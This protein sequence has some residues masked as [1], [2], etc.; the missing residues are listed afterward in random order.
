MPPHTETADCNCAEPERDAFLSWVGRLVHDHR[1]HLLQTRRLRHPS[2]LRNRE[3]PAQ[4]GESDGS[5]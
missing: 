3:R 4:H 1:R 5:T 2:P